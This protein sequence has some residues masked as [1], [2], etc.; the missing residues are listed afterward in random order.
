MGN[1]ACGTGSLVKL[2]LL[3]YILGWPYTCFEGLS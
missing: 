2:Y 1:P 3:K